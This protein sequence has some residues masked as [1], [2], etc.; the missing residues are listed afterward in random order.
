MMDRLLD[1]TGLLAADWSL[2]FLSTVA[3]AASVWNI[4][5]RGCSAPNLAMLVGYVLFSIRMFYALA[6]GDD[7]KI[8]PLGV[9]CWS[10]IAIAWTL[11]ALRHRPSSNHHPIAA[12]E[13][14]Q[15]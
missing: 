3:A 12:H 13:I 6:L 2:A 8:S 15:P 14:H 7:P 4:A 5:R 11:T 1:G 9:V 10:L